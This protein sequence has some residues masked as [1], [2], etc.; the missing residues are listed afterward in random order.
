MKPKKRTGPNPAIKKIRLSCLKFTIVEF[1]KKKKKK[2][3]ALYNPEKKNFSGPVCCQK[4]SPAQGK[5]TPPPAYLMVALLNVA[6][7]YTVIGLP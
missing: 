7:L 2:L 3:L 6:K 5:I 1:V 4:Y